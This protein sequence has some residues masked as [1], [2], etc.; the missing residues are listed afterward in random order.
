MNSN[1]GR[2]KATVVLLTA[3]VLVVSL[4]YWLLEP[5]LRI[6]TYKIPSGLEA[7]VLVRS[8][9]R[10]FYLV[11]GQKSKVP[12][13]PGVMVDGLYRVVTDGTINFLEVRR[14][15]KIVEKQTFDLTWEVFDVTK[16]TDTSASHQLPPI[17][18]F[19]QT[20]LLMPYYG[21]PHDERVI[22]P[23]QVEAVLVWGRPRDDGMR[24]DRDRDFV[25]VAP[26]LEELRQNYPISRLQPNY[27][28]EYV[29][30]LD[31]VNQTNS[32]E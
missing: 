21:P 29:R 30:T 7:S 18:K 32:E 17:A 27:K 9:L 23:S 5:R 13:M 6:S 24:F 15:L 12:Y 22:H 11:M 14:T 19:V 8:K 16:I 31:L 3:I 26:T 25:A 1:I 4:S 2:T 28:W 20:G 10:E